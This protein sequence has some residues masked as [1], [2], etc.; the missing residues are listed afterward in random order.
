M[1]KVLF[2]FV[3]NSGRS[4]MAEALFNQKA[5]AKAAA[6]SAGTQPATQVD[7]T[8]VSVM[9]EVGIDIADSKPKMLTEEMLEGADRIITLGCNVAEACPATFVPTEDRG[10]DDP[11][12]D[13]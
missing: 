2:A 10:L 5:Q 12:E 3:H 8:V 13:R 9:S 4:Q 7:P 11:R 1:K 6:T